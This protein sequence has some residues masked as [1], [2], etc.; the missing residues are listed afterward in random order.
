VCILLIDTDKAVT[1]DAVSTLQAAGFQV[2]CEA[3]DHQGLSRVCESRP[4]LVIVAEHVPGATAEELCCWLRQVSHLPIIVLGNSQEG[5]DKIRILEAG[6]DVCLPK[7]PDAAE[8]VARVRSLLRRTKGPKS[9]LAKGGQRATSPDL[10]E[11]STEST[12]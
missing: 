7:P 8:L 4:D 2:Q 5:G 3:C 12:A 1:P 10:G 9:H 6:A 11:P